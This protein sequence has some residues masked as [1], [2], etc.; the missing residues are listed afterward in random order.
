MGSLKKESLMAR[1]HF[2]LQIKINMRVSSKK[3]FEKGGEN[4]P[5]QMVIFTKVVSKIINE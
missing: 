2:N 1:V 5:V 4:T 3:E